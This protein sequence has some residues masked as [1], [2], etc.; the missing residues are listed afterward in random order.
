MPVA[1]PTSVTTDDVLRAAFA[2]AR[3]MCRRRSLDL[4]L[5]CRCLPREKVDAGCAVLAFFGMIADAIRA[6]ELSVTSASA[7]REHTVI[8]SPASYSDSGGCGSGSVD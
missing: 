1:T 3:G 7:M 2:A 8:A 5:A 4:Y 6:P